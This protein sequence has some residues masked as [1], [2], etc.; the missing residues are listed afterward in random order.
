MALI[1]TYRN[2]VT[3]K[4]DEIA[5]LT[6][7]KAKEKEKIAKARTKI[8]SANVAI[9]RTKSASTVKSKLRDISSAEKDITASEKKISELEKKL[10]KAEK[11]LAEEQKKVKQEEEK[12]HKKRIKKEESIQKKTQKQISE[13][14]RTIQIHE[15][16]QGEMKSQIQELQKLPD[17]ITV[18]FLASNPIDTPSLRLDA[19]ARAIQETIRKSEYRDTIKFETRW[20]VRTSDI[21]QAI[22][23]VNPD[24][25]HFSGHGASNG[26][27]AF[28]NISGQ[29]KL[30][31]KEAMTQTIMTLSD[32]VKLMFFNAC[33]SSAQ[34]KSI[35]EHVDVAIGMN[36][37][38]GDE[39]ALIFA[40][41]FYSSIGFGRNIKIAF[42]QAKAALMLEGIPEET[43]PELFVR[44]SLNAEDIILVKP[45]S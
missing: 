40:S 39:A 10:S 37:S 25:I 19:E 24:I 20:A 43:T 45:F 11:D 7:D 13:L 30:V 12:L 32:K 8:D 28:E 21:L 22:N 31:T 15:Q 29:T 35:V 16:I 6:A 34:A 3:R 18:L 42:D 14:N 44:G 41:Q 1:D 27:L 4:R 33:F 2:N 5:K 38:I 9:N 17:T 23:E 36:T 26:D